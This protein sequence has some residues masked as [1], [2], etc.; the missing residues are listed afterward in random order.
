MVSVNTTFCAADGPRLVTTMSQNA[1]TPATCTV[2]GLQVLVTLRSARATKIVVT[3]DELFDGFGSANSDSTVAVLVMLFVVANRLGSV[4]TTIWNDVVWPG[5]RAP[6]PHW[7]FCPMRVH[8][9]SGSV[10]L[11]NVVPA[12]SVSLT[13]TAW[14]VRV[15]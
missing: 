8:S 4:S 2:S 13:R 10:S 3:L 12:G 6:N 11:K 15:E 1:S 5:P 9:G 7:R 14:A